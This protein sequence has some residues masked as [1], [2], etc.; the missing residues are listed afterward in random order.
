MG[1]WFLPGVR[2][3]DDFLSFVELAITKTGRGKKRKNECH[4]FS[5]E[6]FLR[7]LDGQF[8]T[9][10]GLKLVLSRWKREAKSFLAAFLSTSEKIP[11][12]NSRDLFIRRMMDVFI[13][14]GCSENGNKLRFV[15]S[16]VTADLEEL[17][18]QDPFGTIQKVCFGPGSKAGFAVWNK[19]S[20]ELYLQQLQ[21][22]SA[23]ELEMQGLERGPL[24]VRVALNKRLFNK[25]D[26]EHAGCKIGVDLK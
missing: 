26:L 6:Q 7:T 9:Y 4:D 8:K 2:E 23:N 16:Q 22:S 1:T 3:V 10:R 24:G 20:Q 21:R 15:C 5:S 12:T 13:L 25:V 18:D 14:G 17:I 19:Q 11:S